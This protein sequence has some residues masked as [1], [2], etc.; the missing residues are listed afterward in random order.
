[1][2]LE[3]FINSEPFTFGVELEIQV[4]NTHD[5]DL[6]RAASDLMRLIKDEK[7]PGNITPEITES[8]IE[9]STGICT[10]HEQ[11]VTDLRKIRDVLVSAA[12]QLNVGLAGGGTHAF[13]QWSDRQ[14]YDAPRFQYISEL[15]G[16]LAKQFTVFGQH[17]HIGCPD[18]NSALFLLHSMSR[19]IPHFI[20]LSAS[21]PYI[22]GVDTGFH[23]A[24]LNS[25]FAFPLSGRAPFVLTWDSFEEYFSKMVNT[26]VVNS[27]KDFYWDIRPKPGFGTIEV[28]VM[29]T[30]LSV[31]KAAAIACYIQT[32]SRYLLLD[33][34][35][36]PRE[37]DYL[38]YTFNRFE[39]CRFGLEGT[40]IHPQTGE[41]R[42]IGEDILATLDVLA[43]HAEAL[44]SQAALAEVAEIARGTNDATW[45]RGVVDK[46]KSLHEAVRQQC[47][48][49]RR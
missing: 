34:P 1:M 11:A 19:Y 13:Q 18:P 3:P 45:L 40:C 38:V 30:P 43:P 31:D 12:D 4:V 23:S 27:M 42:T 20:A 49:W 6:T 33:K 9:L 21:S 41:R 47:L 28:R 37:D 32:L 44:G 14:I 7:I 16:Y 29:D 48:Q 2:A 46:E 10:T 5:Y 36:T 17:V 8:M 26:G 35:L 15:Y 25:V 22:Q 39:A 24:R